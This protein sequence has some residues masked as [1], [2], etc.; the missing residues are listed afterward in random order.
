LILFLMMS[1]I[2]PLIIQQL[3]FTS[4]LRF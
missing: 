2:Y 1:G 3:K 4:E